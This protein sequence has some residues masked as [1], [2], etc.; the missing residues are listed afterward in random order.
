MDN[1]GR[2]L[3]G[4]GNNVLD[5]IGT[6][7][8]CGT[9]PLV[10]M[11]LVFVILEVGGRAP[12]VSNRTRCLDVTS[13]SIER[14]SIGAM[15]FDEVHGS[16]LVSTTS[17][18]ASRGAPC[19]PGYGSHSWIARIDGFTP[20]ADVLPPPPLPKPLCSNGLDD[21][22]DGRIDAADP[23]CKSDADNDESRP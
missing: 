16:L 13:E 6:I 23:H 7:G 8:S 12:L 14:I 15:D 18:C 4:A 20:L 17:S 1:E 10:E 9:V 3:Q 19:L 21:D 5:Q 22:G 2:I 11:G